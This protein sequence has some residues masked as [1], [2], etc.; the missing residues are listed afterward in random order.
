MALYALQQG[1]LVNAQDAEQLVQ[2]LTGV[3]NDQQVLLSMN[4][5]NPLVLSRNQALGLQA[6][7]AMQRSGS[8]KYWFGLD[9]NDHFAILN[10]AANAGNMVMDDS[11]NVTFAGSITGG[12]ISGTTGLFT[13]DVDVKTLEATGAASLGSPISSRFVASWTTLGTPTGLTAEVGDFGFDGNRNLWFCTVAGTPGTWRPA[14]MHL[15]DAQSGAGPTASVTHSIP[16][17][18][19]GMYATFIVEF[20]GQSDQSAG[21]A[22]NMQLNGDTGAN[23]WQ[24]VKTIGGT[25]T[26]WG[27]SSGSAS[28]PRVGSIPPSSAPAATFG[29]T[30]VEIANVDSSTLRKTWMSTSFR[31]DADAAVNLSLEYDGGQWVATAAIITSIKIAPAAGNLNKWRSIVYGLSV[32]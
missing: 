1:G 2:L 6:L 27:D 20:T 8:T 9:A 31:Q 5:N 3:M 16:S 22:L 30:R 10:V 17:N 28:T 26:T 21:Q 15:I 4:S 25:S 19:Q 23:Y 24:Q 29:Q 7:Q 11:G 12:A 18:M 13:G 32:A 14:G